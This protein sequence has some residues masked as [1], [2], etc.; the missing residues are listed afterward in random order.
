MP[1]YSPK[2]KKSGVSSEQSKAIAALW[3]ITVFIFTLNAATYWVSPTGAASWA[4]CKSQS[5]LSGTS[6]CAM[7]VANTN[8]AAGDTVWLRAGNF[9]TGIAPANNGTSSDRITYAG[10]P[11]ETV[12]VSRCAIGINV[13]T[14]SYITIDGISTD[15]CRVFADLRSAHH[16]W[17]QNCSLVNPSDTGGW[18]VG[19]LMYTNSRY[20]RIVNC[21][22]G[23]SGYM[24][25]NDDIGG[26]INIGAW[27]DSTDSSGYNLLEGNTFYHGGHHIMEIASKYNI[28]RNNTFHNENWTQCPRTSSGNLCGNRD[29]IIEDDYLDD[30]WN[31]L[32]GNRIA[33]SGASIDD[34][35]GASGMSIRGPHTIVRR[36]MVYGNAGPGISFYADGSGTYDPRH[37]RVYNNVFYKNGISPL[38]KSDFRY[39]FGLLFD[40]VAG[41]NPAIPITDEALK[42]NLFY[43]NT[44]GDAYFYYTSLG[45][46][47][48]TGNY[49]ATASN[50]STP[51]AAINGN[52]VSSADPLFADVS[53]P[54]DVGSIKSFDFHLQPNS[55]AIDKGTFLTVTTGA[56]SGNVI[57]LA[58]A[59]YFIDGYGITGGETIQLQGQ[60]QRA[61]IVSVDY[62]ANKITIDTSLT[63]SSG[64]GV[65]LA[66]SGTAPDIGAFEYTSAY[67]IQGKAQPPACYHFFRRAEG[68]DFSGLPGRPGDRIE[69]RIY[70]V[71]GKLMVLYANSLQSRIH[72]TESTL[73]QG[74]YIYSITL[75]GRQ[76]VSG[77]I[78]KY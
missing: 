39:T 76:A 30:Y 27:E 35:T 56:G 11:G 52:I 64:Q 45:L 2:T 46:Q 41:N 34:A 10:Y 25:S 59:S 71:S 20:N 7:A 12:S 23:N 9:Q 65:A 67:A 16:I 48:F 72:V 6:A 53:A 55:P 78:A 74:L 24:T 14:K 37:S 32:E 21:T 29:I 4:N 47:T 44:G 18:P 61:H 36:N 54:A 69:V 3:L 49:Y 77:R 22:T 19:I 42:N 38:S 28:I 68:V 50:N 1:L 73:A 31:V 63:W 58:D 51:M 8:A 33:F 66:Y 70:S 5:P 62:S 17:V 40:D 60:T 75:N 57:T 43:Q 15:S 13:R 26:L